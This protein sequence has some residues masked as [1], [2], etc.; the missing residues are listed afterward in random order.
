MEEFATDRLL[1]SWVELAQRLRESP[2]RIDQTQ[3]EEEHSKRRHA[4]QQ[5]IEEVYFD[6]NKK[7]ELSSDDIRKFG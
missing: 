4:V 7:Q 3:G 6:K 5:W 2:E 1:E